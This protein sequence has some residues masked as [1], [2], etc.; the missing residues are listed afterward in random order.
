M[1]RTIWF[2]MDGTIADFYSVPGWLASLEAEHTR[3]YREARP[4]GNMRK[5]SHLL[6]SLQESGCKIGIISWT[7]KCGT[8][9]FNQAVALAKIAWLNRHLG[10]VIFDEINIIPYGT[11]KNLFCENSIDILFDDE[12]PNRENWTG[13]AYTPDCIMEI[14]EKILGE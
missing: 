1:N 2:D 6:N 10:S 5:L 3:P 7:S 4:I 9:E 11:P 13:E 12:A 14:L 8:P